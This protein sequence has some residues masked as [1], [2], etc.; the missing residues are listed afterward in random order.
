ML[1]TISRSQARP[2]EALALARHSSAS[3]RY[4]A[5]GRRLPPGRSAEA[6][7]L[8]RL[9]HYAEAVDAQTRALERECP[10]RTALLAERLELYRKGQPYLKSP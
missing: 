5:Q 6:A 7:Q 3:S 8:R 1:A 10:P 9:G 4:D 2:E